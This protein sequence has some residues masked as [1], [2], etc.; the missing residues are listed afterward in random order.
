VS[1]AVPPTTS[2]STGIMGIDSASSHVYAEAVK[3]LKFG[4]TVL[5]KAMK[6][7]ES[8]QVGNCYNK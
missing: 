3:L 5:D 6:R 8:E 7:H 1:V 2:T 4:D